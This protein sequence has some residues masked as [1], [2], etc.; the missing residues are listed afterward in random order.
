MRTNYTREEL[1]EICEKAIVPVNNWCNRDTSHTQ[2]QIG[3]C[4][5]LLKSGCEFKVCVQSSDKEDSCSMCCTDEQ[6]IWISIKFPG[7][8]YFETGNGVLSRD[9]FYLPTMKRL[10]ANAESDWY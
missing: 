9:I 3:Q 8:D 10:S 7:F 1:I 6:T 4:W 2:C 5:A